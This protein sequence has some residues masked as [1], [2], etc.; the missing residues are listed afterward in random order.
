MTILTTEQ[1]TTRTGGRIEIRGTMHP[2]FDEVLTPEALEFLAQLHDR[3]GQ[4]RCNLL[5]AR[6]E[7][8]REISQGANL[9][10]LAETRHIR[11]D[12]SWQVAGTGPGLEDRRVEITGPTDRK[13]TINAMNSGAKVWLADHEDATSPTWFN[14]IDGQLNLADAIRRRIDFTADNGKAYRLGEETPTIVFRPRGWHLPENHLRYVDE[15]GQSGVVS[16]SLVDFGLYFFHNAKELLATGTGPYFYLPK[17]EN[18]REARLWN[19]V[20]TFAERHVGVPYGSVRATVLIETITAAFEMEEIL[21]ELRDHCAG[22]NAGRWDYL[23]SIIKTFRDRSKRWVLPNRG[24]LSMTQPFMTAYTELLVATC[25]RRGAFA[26][27]GMAAFI[28]NRSDPEATARALE[29][30]SADKRREAAAGFDGSWVAHPGLVATAQAEF[31]EVLGDAPNQISRQ[32][33]DVHVTAADLLDLRI[34]G[35]EITVEEGLKV[36]IRVAMLYI[37]SWLRGTGAAAIYGLMEDAAT[38]EISRSQLWQWIHQGVV[39]QDDGIPVVRTR[40]EGCIERVLREDLERFEGDRLD[41]AAGLLAEI[42]LSDDYP[43]FL[44]IPAYKHLTKDTVL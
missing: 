10:F 9:D 25:H 44:T 20:F 31:D 28:P 1:T 22:L 41:E 17:L 4:R 32:R 26:I 43:A 35:G 37:A 11:E 30:V 12:A 40:I 34:E 29:K 27:G 13:M 6:E 15:R 42:V 33:P 8:R 23:F 7:R 5:A 24:Q 36:N 3:F 19:D 39:T 2:R 18:H 21:Y 38:A 14:V 16:A